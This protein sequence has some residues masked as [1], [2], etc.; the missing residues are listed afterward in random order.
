MQVL[1]THFNISAYEDDKSTTTSLLEG[2]VLVRVLNGKGG[3]V[4]SILKPNQQ[5]VLT[6]NVIKIREIDPNSP[7][8][9]KN[10]YFMFTGESI[11]SIM[12]KLSRW[13]DVDINYQGKITREVFFGSVSKYEHISEVLNTLELT[14]LVHFKIEERRITVMP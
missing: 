13:Y 10:G 6:G 5:S 12:K 14:G 1:G 3:A 4:S 8:A 9:W 11:E 2:S 7:V